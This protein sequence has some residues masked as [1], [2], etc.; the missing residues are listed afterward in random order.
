MRIPHLLSS[1][2]LLIFPRLYRFWTKPV[3]ASQETKCIAK[4]AEQWAKAEPLA[5]AYRTINI[6]V[7]RPIDISLPKRQSTQLRLGRFHFKAERRDRE[8]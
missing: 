1:C 8:F 6:S 3:V 5:I 7:K 4:I 2:L